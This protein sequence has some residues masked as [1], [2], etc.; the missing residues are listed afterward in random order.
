MSS[1]S[2]SLDTALDRTIALGYGNVGLEIRRPLWDLC[3]SLV[4]SGAQPAAA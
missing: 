3:R 1:W 2:G 4:D